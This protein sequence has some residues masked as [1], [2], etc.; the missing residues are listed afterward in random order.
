MQTRPV[1][2]SASAPTQRLAIG[3][4][5]CGSALWGLY[6]L[7][8]R[9]IEQTGLAGL[10]AIALIYLSATAVFLFLARGDLL[11]LRRVSRWMLGIGLSSAISGVAFSI[12]VIEGEVARVLILFYLSPIWS[13]LLAR[14]VLREPLAPVTIPALVV[15]LV[16]AGMMLG[17]EPVVEDVGR[18]DLLGLVAGLAFAL[19]NVQLRAASDLPARL[20]NLAACYLI[21]PLAIGAALA[22]D[23]PLIAPPWAVVASVGLGLVWMCLMV[24]AVQFGVSHMPLQRSSVLLLFELVVGAVSAA[25]IAGETLSPWELA[26]GLC[27]VAAGLAVVWG[28]MPTTGNTRA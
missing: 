18:A 6:W 16:G 17:A 21:P 11:D 13:V 19:T 4:M 2:P 7:P 28:R 27:I 12:G 1:P 25:W 24:A 8:L 10:W 23:V 9:L 22:T 15:A 3:A 26:G 5:L 14:L 20:K